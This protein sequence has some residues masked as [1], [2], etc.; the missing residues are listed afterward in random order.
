[1]SSESTRRRG[2]RTVSRILRDSRRRRLGPVEYTL[3]TLIALG[4]AV[5][6]VMAIVNP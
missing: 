4:V 6:V 3:L 5:T 2:A 1:M